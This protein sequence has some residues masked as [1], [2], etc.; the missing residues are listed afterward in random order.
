MKVLTPEEIQKKREMYERSLAQLDDAEQDWHNMSTA[1][2]LAERLHNIECD[3]KVKT[4]YTWDKDKKP[5]CSFEEG[6]WQDS[7]LSADKQKYIDKIE[8]VI[9]VIPVELSEE[10]LLEIF[11]A[12]RE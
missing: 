3:T 2:R 12:F 6:T 1:Q 9:R 4:H 8:T 5:Y 10:Q 11:E 7:T